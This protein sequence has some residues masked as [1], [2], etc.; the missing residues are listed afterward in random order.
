[1]S[2]TEVPVRDP[3]RHFLAMLSQVPLFF[4]IQISGYTALSALI[5]YTN[6]VREL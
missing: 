6:V 1:M 4:A 3:D 2:H 5:D